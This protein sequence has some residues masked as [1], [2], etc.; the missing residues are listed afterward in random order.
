MTAQLGHIGLL[1]GMRKDPHWANVTALLEMT[2]SN[3][4]TTFTDAKGAEWTPWGNAQIQNNQ[5][6]LDGT[7]DYL[8]TP[9]NDSKFNFGLG[10]FTIEVDMTLDN[11][12]D[13]YASLLASGW[14]SF[15]SGSTALMVYGENVTNPTSAHRKKVALLNWSYNPIFVSQAQLTAGQQYRIAVS[16]TD[17]VMRLFINGQLDTTYSGSGA[18]S[19]IYFAPQ[20]TLIGANGW[21]GASSQMDGRIDRIRITKGVGRYLSN[22]NAAASWPKR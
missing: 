6:E 11:F 20:G 2:G 17:G 5:L 9:E 22:Y 18:G 1:T 10:D 7:G 12:T 14:A 4:S 19:D 15:G 21:D 16:R 8:K 13:N 3:G